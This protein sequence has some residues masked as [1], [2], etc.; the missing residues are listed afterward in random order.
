MCE[1]SVE[2]KVISYVKWVARDSLAE[3]KEGAEMWRTEDKQR[4]RK[5]H[6]KYTEKAKLILIA[7]FN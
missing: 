7:F 6:I 5:V 4:E 1:E 2:R 3:S